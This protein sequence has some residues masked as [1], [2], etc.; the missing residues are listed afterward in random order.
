MTV[1]DGLV[2]RAYENSWDRSEKP[3]YRRTYKSD[4]ARGGATCMDCLNAQHY[5]CRGVDG[6]PCNICGGS[7]T[8]DDMTKRRTDRQLARTQPVRR[9]RAKDPSEPRG[10]P[11]PRVLSESEK[12][13]IAQAVL[14]LTQT[15][16]NYRYGIPTSVTSS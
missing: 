15:L 6:C 11:G 8:R 2:N 12:D 14:K 13:E 10:K 5:R 16:V 4:D 3:E 1:D 7:H 9:S